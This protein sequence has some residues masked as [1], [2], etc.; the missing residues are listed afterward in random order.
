MV[1]EDTVFILGA[2]A[3]VPYGYPSGA[4]L[5]LDICK[6]FVKRIISLGQIHHYPEPEVK[7]VIQKARPFCDAFFKSS[8]PSID[9]FLARNTKFSEIGK[10]AIL[11]SIFEAEKNSKFR[12]D[13]DDKY[14]SQDW[15]SLLFRKMTEDFISPNSYRDFCE[16]K[17]TFVT[18]NYDRSLEHFL[19]ESL[20]N[21]FGSAPKDEIINQL[22]LINVFHVYGVIDKLAWQGGSTEYKVNYSLATLKKMKDNVKLI[23]ER[24]DLDSREMKRAMHNTKRFYILGFGYAEENLDVLGIRKLLDGDQK[25]YGTALGMTEKEISEIRQYL[26]MNFREKQIQLENPVIE[27]S[28][29]YKLLK[30][31]F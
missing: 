8:T 23:H 21:A 18:F 30:E 10:M 2:G 20:S 9:L 17:V 12:E 5:R 28:D 1:T 25:I 29:S 13:M 7:E 11:S 6:R 15:Y 26:R 22:R 16:N 4:E 27:P 3:S 19:F 14:K 31:W 24:I